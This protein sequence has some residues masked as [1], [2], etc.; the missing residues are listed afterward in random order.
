MYG[1]IFN[2]IDFDDDD[3]PLSMVEVNPKDG[4][5]KLGPVYS[6]IRE[7]CI[8]SIS[9]KYSV[10]LIDFLNLP[11]HMTDMLIEESRESLRQSQKLKNNVESDTRKQLKRDGYDVR[12]M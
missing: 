12:N 3:R 7:Y 8:Y 10:D 4:Y 2:V 11:R 9:E 6:R 5:N 1:T